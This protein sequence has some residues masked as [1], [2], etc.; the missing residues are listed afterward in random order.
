MF[1]QKLSSSIFD[2]VLPTSSSSPTL[3]AFILITTF[4]FH[5]CFHPLSF[6]LVIFIVHPCNRVYSPWSHLPLLYTYLL[7][8]HLF[9]SYP[10]CHHSYS[11]CLSLLPCHEICFCHLSSSSSLPCCLHFCQFACI[12]SFSLSTP[13]D[14][15][16]NSFCA[17]QAFGYS[18]PS[19]SQ[20]QQT[21]SFV[22]FSIHMHIHFEPD[23]LDMPPHL[24]PS[25]PAPV[26]RILLLLC[27]L[28]VNYFSP[29][30]QPT[31]VW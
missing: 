12:D 5:L 7:W 10:F 25:P 16:Y 11:S 14:P 21:V 1:P 20:H 13:L 26:C 18:S 27:L 28:V 6:I 30:Q 3:I 15:M 31:S 17:P 8:S 19:Y 2:W 24:L 4:I 22:L 23:T 9:G 29:L